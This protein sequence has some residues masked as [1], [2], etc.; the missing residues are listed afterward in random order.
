MQGSGWVQ[1]LVQAKITSA[2][3]ADSFLRASHV[4]R[5]R[6]AHQVTAAALFTLQQH[7]YNHYIDQLDDVGTEQLE[8]ADWCQRKAETCPQFH[9]WA[10]VLQLELTV[11]VYARSIS[12]P[13]VVCDVRR[14]PQRTSCVVPCP[15]SHQL[16][17][18]DSCASA[19]HGGIA[20]DTP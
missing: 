19:R 6:R 14:C 3:T 17:A 1:A 15:G 10:T 13:S 11:L 16:R 7:A 20:D 12:A 8:F 2:G 4:S 5:T 18:L 9:Y